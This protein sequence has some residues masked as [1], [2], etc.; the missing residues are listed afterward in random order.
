MHY[1]TDKAEKTMSR[2]MQ[3]KLTIENQ[4]NSN[5]KHNKKQ[6][7]NTTNVLT[8]WISKKGKLC[9]VFPCIR[10][11]ELG[12]IQVGLC[13]GVRLRILLLPRPKQGRSV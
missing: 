5:N 13:K 12:W 3:N 9:C 10:I 4:I 7:I 6:K 8:S 11:S 2:D 1:A